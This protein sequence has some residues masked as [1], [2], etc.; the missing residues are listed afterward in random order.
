MEGNTATVDSREIRMLHTPGLTLDGPID[1]PLW[2]S[3]FGPRSHALAGDIADGIIGPPHPTVPAAM[4][5]S[6]TVLYRGEDSESERVR[7][8]IGPWRV[9]DWHNTY[10]AAGAIGVDDCPG[11]QAWREAIEAVS[12]NENRHLFTFEAHVTHLVDRDR[13]RTLTST[14]WWDRPRWFADRSV[15]WLSRVCRSDLYADRT[16]CTKRDCCIRRCAGERTSRSRV[17]NSCGPDTV[18]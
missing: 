2:M 18:T 3:T 10:A 1:V 5:T 11:G 15:D 9:V 8:V 14:P 13:L 12:S 17:N 16:R 4:I 7:E 6:G